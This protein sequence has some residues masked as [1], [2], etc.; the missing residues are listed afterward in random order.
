M[1]EQETSEL[2]ERIEGTLR[3]RHVAELVDRRDDVIVRVIRERYDSLGVNPPCALATWCDTELRVS[4]ATELDALTSLAA[5]LGLNADGSDPRTEL[6]TLRAA[7]LADVG[8]LTAERDAAYAI[9]AGR[10]TPPTD[11]EVG[12][13]ERV[14]G[15]GSAWLCMWEGRPRVIEHSS[16]VRYIRGTGGRPWWPLDATGRPCAWPTV[17]P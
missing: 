13:H 2:R 11:A 14:N 17:A 5:T 8:R 3:D 15:L 6:E 4:G 16:G 1:N 7:A 12:A 10:D 9:I